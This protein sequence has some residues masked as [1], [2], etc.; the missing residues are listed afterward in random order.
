[1]YGPK[2]NKSRIK[3]KSEFLSPYLKFI[4]AYTVFFRFPNHIL[5]LKALDQP[6]IADEESL[7]ARDIT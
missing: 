6:Q 2:V 1:M 3:A 7:V 5:K 4:F